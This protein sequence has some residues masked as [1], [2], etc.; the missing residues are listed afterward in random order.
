MP[1]L[2][3]INKIV[4]WPIKSEHWKQHP[5]KQ[6]G[7]KKNHD[8][9]HLNTII[10]TQNVKECFPWVHLEKSGMWIGMRTSIRMRIHVWTWTRIQTCRNTTE[11]I[12]P[13][14]TIDREWNKAW[15]FPLNEKYTVLVPVSHVQSHP[16]MHVSNPG[17]LWTQPFFYIW[18]GHWIW[19][20]M[21]VCC[22]FVI[23]TP[24]PKL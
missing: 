4:L 13:F 16:G 1:N 5:I 7:S 14:W 11:S 15:I 9:G 17:W 20:Y 23:T 12:L 10:W 24:P 22:T 2:K 19:V 8:T 18:K 6:H 21:W 3:T